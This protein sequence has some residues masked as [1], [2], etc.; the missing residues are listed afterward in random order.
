MPTAL[1]ADAHLGGPGGPPGPLVEQLDSLR[2][3]RCERLVLLGDLFQAWVGSPKF[4]STSIAQVV[5]ALRRLR[6]RGVPV[7]YIEGNRDFFLAGSPYA[8][9]F[10]SIGSEVAF[11]SG[12]RRYLAVHGDGLNDRDWQYLA[13]RGLAKSR[14]SRLLVLRTPH[15]FAQ[16]LVDR[17]ERKLSETNFKH[18]IR[19]PEAAIRA[20]AERRLAEGHDVLL[21]GHFHEPR[22]WQVPGGEVRLLDAW[23]NSHQLEWL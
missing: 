20:Y 7:H 6:A 13:W 18:K 5:A 8:D 23:F 21:L 14:L 17:T 4:E 2:P 19:L 15:R 11:T 16:R 22:T 9:A 1:I 3:E 12:G 10:D